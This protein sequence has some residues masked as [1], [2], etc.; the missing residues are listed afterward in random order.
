VA[1]EGATGTGMRS[2]RLCLTGPAESALKPSPKHDGDDALFVFCE[3]DFPRQ[4]R[5]FNRAR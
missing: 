4:V 1:L 2:I 5:R 3:Q